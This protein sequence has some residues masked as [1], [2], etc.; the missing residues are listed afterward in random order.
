MSDIDRIKYAREVVGGDPLATFLGI[1]VEE[2]LER[3]AVV[4]LIPGPQHM[5][6]VERVHGS[7][8]YAL[9]DQAAAVAANTLPGGA[10]VFEAKVNFLDAGLPGE[11]LTAAAVPLDVKRKLSLWEVRVSAPDGRLVATA[12]AMAYHL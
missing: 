9:V 10:V 5:N 8:I 4:S 11:K 2:V 1:K 7:A 3:R 6:A 12:Q